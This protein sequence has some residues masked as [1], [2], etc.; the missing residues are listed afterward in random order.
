[1]P[2]TSLYRNDEYTLK[3]ILWRHY[4][5][6]EQLAPVW[7]DCSPLGVLNMTHKGNTRGPIA[8]HDDVFSSPSPVPLTD[9]FEQA[10][11]QYRGRMQWH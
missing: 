6:C 4:L 8:E 1:M 9:L 3:P 10:Y 2:L 11:Q 5:L 7:H